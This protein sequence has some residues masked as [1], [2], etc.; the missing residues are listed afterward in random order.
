MTTVGYGDKAPKTV[1]GRVLGLVWMFIAIVLIGTFIANMSSALT[2]SQLQT[3]IRGP[4]DLGN[5]TVATVQRSAS[6]AFLREQRIPFRYAD[7]LQ[8]AL[9]QVADGKIDAAVYDAPLMRYLAT[10]G[11]QDE[12][13]VL[14]RTFGRQDYSIAL[15]SGSPYR[16]DINRILL[17]DE[18]KAILQDLLFEYLEQEEA[19][20]GD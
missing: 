16:E 7:D 12:I 5:A 17:A 6:E 2:V 14:P 9:A 11:F 10:H 4:E 13:D 1:P 15:P 8:G 19:P 18:T 20:G 3:P